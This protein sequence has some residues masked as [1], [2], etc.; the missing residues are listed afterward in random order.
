MSSENGRGQPVGAGVEDDIEHAAADGTEHAA[1][2]GTERAVWDVLRT[3][4]DPELPVSIVDL[5]LIYDV[6]VDDGDAAIELTVTYSGCPGREMI[7]NDAADA[8]RTVEGIDDV[9]VT[10]VYS[11][12]WSVDRI[13]DRGREKLTEFGLAIPGEKTD[14]D[15]DCHD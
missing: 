15:P 10:V 7:V 12:Q 6:A 3:V 1:V 4:E 8:V 5:G 14:P 2:D 13:T 9:E 11:P